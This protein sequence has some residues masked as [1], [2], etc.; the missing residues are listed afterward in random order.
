M[1]PTTYLSLDALA[2]TFGLPRTYLRELA[3]AGII[4]CLRVRGRLRFDE[5]AV[6]DALRELAK[7]QEGVQHAQ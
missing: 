2:V 3:N 5:R 7:G 4:P 1:E 6:R